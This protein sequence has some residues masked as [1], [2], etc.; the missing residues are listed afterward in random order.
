[1]RY[2]ARSDAGLDRGY[3]ALITALKRQAGTTAGQG[4]PSS[5]LQLRQ[6]QRAWLVY[7]DTECRR[8]NRGTE[9]PLWA[10]TRAGCLGE[11]S[12]V[13]EAEIAGALR[14]LEGR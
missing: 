5:V 1:M 7:R 9:G 14:K 12:S 10:P 13:R 11:F 6:A 4:E 8:R 2:L 3:Q